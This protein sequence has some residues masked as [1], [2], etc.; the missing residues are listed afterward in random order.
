MGEDRCVFA[1]LTL[2]R[3]YASKMSNTLQTGL[4]QLGRWLRGEIPGKGADDAD[5]LRRA[6]EQNRWFI[7]SF[8]RDAM[9]ACGEMLQIRVMEQWMRPYKVTANTN[10]KRVGLIL[11]GN[12]PMVG[13]HDIVCVLLAGHLPV[14]K[15]STSDGLL[16]PAALSFLAETNDEGEARFEFSAGQLGQVDAV[17]A[18]GSSNSNRYFEAYFNHLPRILR[19]QRTSVAVLNG[20]ESSEAIRDLGKDVFQ[21]YGMGCRSVTKLFLPRGF[22][23]NRLFR[24]WLEW[25]FL[26]N[27]NKYANNYDYHKAIWL[28]NGEE[29]LENG[30]LLLKEDSSLFS[31]VGTLFYEFYDDIHRVRERLDS[32]GHLIQCISSMQAGGMETGSWPTYAFGSNQCPLPWDYADGIDTMEFLLA[33]SSST[34]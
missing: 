20:S 25:D 6:E 27:N 12:I 22:D 8:T 14:V 33:L 10:P 26:A 4:V 7:P 30:F 18:T 2:A 31:P 19:S 28:L 34:H 3:R 1:T 21:Y 9:H 11:A 15:C 13:F 5:L 23:L 16:I 24:E 29:L 17:I 32:D